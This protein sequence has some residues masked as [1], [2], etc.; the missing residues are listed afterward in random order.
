MCS[1]GSKHVSTQHISSSLLNLPFEFTL[2]QIPKP[3]NHVWK[4]N[5]KKSFLY[6]TLTS[7]THTKNQALL[8]LWTHTKMNTRR[9][10]NEI[11]TFELACVSFAIGT[12]TQYKTILSLSLGAKSC[13]IPPI[14]VLTSQSGDPFV[15]VLF[16]YFHNT[17]MSKV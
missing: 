17:L 13:Y 1:K 12:T 16:K 11:K 2:K 15:L 6:A 8:I 3:I 9:H 4:Q 10:K 7:L 14:Q 5:H